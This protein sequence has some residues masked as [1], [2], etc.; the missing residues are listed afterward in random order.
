MGS[1]YRQTL[2]NFKMTKNLII[3]DVCLKMGTNFEICLNIILITSEVL[4]RRPQ[5]QVDVV[6]KLLELRHPRVYGMPLL[7][8][9]PP[10][11][12]HLAATLPHNTLRDATDGMRLL[13]LTEV[14]A[15]YTCFLLSVKISNSI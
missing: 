8:T 4:G 2:Y 15:N 10:D 3:F 12:L 11:T 13:K 5:V 9:P 14:N 7:A 1:T 6:E